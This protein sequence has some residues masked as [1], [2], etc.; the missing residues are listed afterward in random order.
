MK[1]NHPSIEELREQF[2]YDPQDGSMWKRVGHETGHGY[3]R[4]SIGVGQFLQAHRLAWAL[5]YGEWPQHHVDHINGDRSDNRLENLR[6]I[7]QAHNQQNERKARRSSKSGLLGASW[8][9]AMGHW[10][11][12][13]HYDGKH[14]FLGYFSTAEAAHAAYLK[15]KRTVHAGCTI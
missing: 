7:P 13:I 11:A 9:K 10:T 8:N 1:K 4:V 2:R 6:D 3:Q 14:H 15:A 12:R 5:V